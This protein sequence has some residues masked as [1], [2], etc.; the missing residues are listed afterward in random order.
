MALKDKKKK[1][2]PESLLDRI[3]ARIQITPAKKKR[4]KDKD[5]K[6]IRFSLLYF[7]LASLIIIML[8]HLL[9]SEEYKEISYS[10]F[11]KNAETGNIK[12]LVIRPKSI[13][14]LIIQAKHGKKDVLL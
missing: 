13:E 12:K 9:I 1:R 5:A 4:R 11:K 8:Q 3:L 14:G 7:I 10:E 2:E 6:P